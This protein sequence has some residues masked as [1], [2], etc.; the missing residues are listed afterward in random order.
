MRVA[1]YTI[2]AV[3]PDTAAECAVFFFGTG[4]G[5]NVEDNIQRWIGQ[6]ETSETPARSTLQV[7]GLKIER[8]ALGGTY[9]ASGGMMQS[10][11]PKPNYRLLGAIVEAPE[12]AV[13]FKLTGPSATV[14]AAETEFDQL[15]SSIKR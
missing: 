11:E 12:G 10:A 6:F 9:L 8:I 3:P 14:A 1:T 5:G 4:Q 2:P 15:V 7:N 13:F